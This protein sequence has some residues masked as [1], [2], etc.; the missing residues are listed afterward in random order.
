ME[1]VESANP[2]VV[3]RV[4][5]SREKKRKIEE[6]TEE[7]PKPKI[8]TLG[9][10]LQDEREKIAENLLEDE[11]IAHY[12]AF[13]NYSKEEVIKE[14]DAIADQYADQLYQAQKGE[15]QIVFLNLETGDHPKT[16]THICNNISLIW[17]LQSLCIPARCPLFRAPD[18][19]MLF[20][21]GDYVE[22][23]EDNP[24]QYKYL[25]LIG[26]QSLSSGPASDAV[27]RST[28]S[29]G[30]VGYSIHYQVRFVFDHVFSRKELTLFG[31]NVMK[32][33]KNRYGASLCR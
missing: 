6:G 7:A 19:V 1:E 32:C 28:V 10:Y 15:S 11:T 33:K 9:Q 17:N 27:S 23:T 21:R 5:R 16:F 20:V 8:Q 13:S 2:A 25:G 22:G 4:T 24:D 12:E 26:I 3:E 18:V 29:K 30:G 14:F 31:N